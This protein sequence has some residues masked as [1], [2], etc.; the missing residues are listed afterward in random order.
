[1]YAYNAHIEF[2]FWLGEYI[3]AK[4]EEIPSLHLL[5][6]DIYVKLNEALS[7]TLFLPF[8]LTHT[9]VR[10]KSLFLID[11]SSSYKYQ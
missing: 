7:H 8:S 3:Y 10:Y 2:H 5:F 11:L 4:I 9:Y 6:L 1:M